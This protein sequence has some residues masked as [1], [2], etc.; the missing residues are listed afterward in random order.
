MVRTKK[1]AAASAVVIRAIEHQ[2]PVVLPCVLP[3]TIGRFQD[4][5]HRKHRDKQHPVPG[6]MTVLRGHE[7]DQPIQEHL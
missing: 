6:P 1:R 2:N 4:A 3:E 5:Q 7:I